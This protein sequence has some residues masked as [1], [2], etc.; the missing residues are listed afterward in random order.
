MEQGHH[1]E[2]GCGHGHGRFFGRRWGTPTPQELT[3]RLQ[4]RR[5]RLEQ[6]LANV[7]ELIKRL[8]DPEQPAQ[9]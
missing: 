2:G 1:H 6:E 8:G 4:A 9:A 5:E 3:E 7:Q